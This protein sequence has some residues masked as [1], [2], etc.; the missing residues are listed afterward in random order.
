MGNVLSGAFALL[1]YALAAFFYLWDLRTTRSR[2]GWIATGLAVLGAAANFGFLYHRARVHGTVPYADLLGSMALFGFFLA[3]MNLIL[4]FRHRDRALGPFL[5]PVAFLFLVVAFAVP[6]AVTPPKNDLKGPVFALHV[7]LN[8]LSY[9]AFAV[10]CALS[11]LYLVL[12]RRLKGKAKSLFA[13][14]ASHLPSL[15][16]LER[17]ARTSIGVGVAGLGAGLALGAAWASHVWRAEHPS[18]FLDAKVLGALFTLVYYFT[19]WVRAN[20]GA[21]PVTTARLAVA[22]FLL[23]LFS[24]TAVNLLFSRLHSFT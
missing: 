18:W 8:M 14:P 21:A 2:E 5:M 24:Y 10:A 17:A 12:R 16:Y 15:S 4:E 3:V 20:R 19:V 7:T 23:V 9:A 13:G 1:C 6:H 22:G 11:V